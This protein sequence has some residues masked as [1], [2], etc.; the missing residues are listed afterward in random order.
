MV[1]I[2]FALENVHTL[3]NQ[4]AQLY[5]TQSNSF[6]YENSISSSTSSHRDVFNIQ[7][8]NTELSKT[9]GQV[10]LQEWKVE[11]FKTNAQKH[12]LILILL[13]FQS[14]GNKTSSRIP[15]H[16]PSANQPQSNCFTLKDRTWPLTKKSPL[17]VWCHKT[18]RT[19]QYLENT[20]HFF[21]FLPFLK[22]SHKPKIFFCLFFYI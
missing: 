2:K 6:Q 8:I 14:K 7:R 18:E 11:L 5:Y 10:L 13:S 19:K 17:Q 15:L 16:N 22:Q 1:F 4:H 9:S 3:N 21:F 20:K 12:K